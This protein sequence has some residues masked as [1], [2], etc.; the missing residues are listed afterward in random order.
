MSKNF[1]LYYSKGA[2]TV[3]LPPAW[4][5]VSEEIAANVQGVRE[6]MGELAK[7][8]AKALMLSFGD[9]KED[10][11]RMEALTQEITDLLKKSEEIAV[12]LRQWAF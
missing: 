4:V 3:G 8:H 11:S 5:D 1:V 9:G 2:L 12:T 7:A 10:Q 6:K